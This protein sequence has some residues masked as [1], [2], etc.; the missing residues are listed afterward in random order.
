MSVT[1]LGSKSLGTAVPA[2]GASL[3]AITAM[4][5]DVAN[6]LA[7]VNQ[8]ISINTALTTTLPDPLGLAA[9]LATAAAAVAGLAPLIVASYPLPL[10]ASASLLAADL[11]ALNALS[12]ALNAA[13][14]TLTAAA[15]TGGIHVL[16]ADSTGGSIGGELSAALSGVVTASARV[17]GVIM[18]TESPAA[19]ATMGSVLLTA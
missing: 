18:L 3:G 15:S 9:S 14:A 19:F 16:S 4:L 11:A 7:S 5:S 8:Q 17:Q 2:I 6:R 10:A 1:Y 13:S 12:A